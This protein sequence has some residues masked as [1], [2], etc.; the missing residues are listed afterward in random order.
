[1]NHSYIAGYFDGEGCLLL[2]I[3]HEKR[4]EKKRGS[5]VDGWCIAPSICIQ[6]YDYEVL[7][8]MYKELGKINILVSTFDM[9]K[10]HGLNLK[11]ARR[12]SITGWKNVEDFAK[13]IYPLCYGKKEQLRLFF[14]LKKLRDSTKFI[15][16]QDQFLEAMKIVDSINSL[17]GGNRGQRNYSFFKELF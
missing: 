7:E 16:R 5:L 2:G 3:T 11:D 14:E 6:S 13:L 4:E 12:L 8:L 17:K 1:V 15:W 9:K 10:K